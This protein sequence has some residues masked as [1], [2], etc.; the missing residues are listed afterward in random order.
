MDT[1][2][3]TIKVAATF[4]NPQ[5]LLRPGQYARVRGTTSTHEGAVVLPQRALVDVQGSKQVFIVG[6]DGKIAIRPV[7]V[8]PRYGSLWVIEQGVEAGETVVVEGQQ[9]S[10]AGEK[11]TPKPWT[12]DQDADAKQAP[13]AATSQKPADP[14]GKP[15]P[16]SK[17]PKAATNKPAAKSAKPGA[18]NSK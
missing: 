3:G 13:A 15:A 14:P 6:A 9:K 2:T 11:V 4:P 5:S 12:A 10:R 18:G 7:T 8:G 1:L 16:T 17:K